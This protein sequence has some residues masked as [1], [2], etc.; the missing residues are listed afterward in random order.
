M[1]SSRA[2]SK[3]F[4]RLNSDP[5]STK[6]DLHTLSYGSAYLYLDWILKN[7]KQPSFQLITGIGHHS[8]HEFFEMKNKVK[9]YLKNTSPEWTVKDPNPGYLILSKRSDSLLG[10][11]F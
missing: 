5:S 3:I 7:T 6:F 11:P 10:S 4:P 8:P 2:T 1:K 9:N